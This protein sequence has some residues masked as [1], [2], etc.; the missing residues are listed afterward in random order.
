MLQLTKRALFTALGLTLAVPARA[1][2]SQAPHGEIALWPG[3]PPGG[4]PAGLV[5]R[6]Q[7]NTGPGGRR[8]RGIVGVTR[9][10]LTLVQPKGAVTG[11][12]VIV[13]GGGFRQ[14]VIDKEG[15]EIAERLA[16]AGILSGVLT[17]RLPAEDPRNGMIA[18]RQDMQR[19]MRLMRQAAGP[20]RPMGVMGFSAGGDLVGHLGN[21]PDEALY[22]AVDEA[23][24]QP[25]R[26]DYMALIYGS[27]G[28]QPRGAGG[29]R[30]PGP[31]GRPSIPDTVNAMTPPA[32]MAQAMNDPKVSFENATEMTAALHAK[33]IGAE[34]HLFEEGDHGF[35]LRRGPEMPVSRW[36]DLFLAWGRRHGFL[37]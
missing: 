37:G 22:T 4:L 3:E 9:P 21:Q 29:A 25:A 11:A 30:L 27:L 32:F 24:R 5:Q 20:E 33:G 12:L 8:D 15:L 31:P 18:A 36:P 6:E 1:A 28:V 34:L 26:A 14:I 17:H 16:A 19:A 7:W 10:T 35:G 23:D 13:P 2:E